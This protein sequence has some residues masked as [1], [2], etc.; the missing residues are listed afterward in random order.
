MPRAAQSRPRL[1]PRAPVPH[2]NRATRRA[3][4][5]APANQDPL[6]S[7]RP[8]IQ[9]RSTDSRGQFVPRTL[10][11][12]PLRRMMLRIAAERLYRRADRE[13]HVRLVQE[14]LE[15]R[16][17]RGPRA[18]VWR[19]RDNL[20]AAYGWKAGNSRALGQLCGRARG[21]R[22]RL[23]QEGDF[24]ASRCCRKHPAGIAAVSASVSFLARLGVQPAPD[25]AKH[26]M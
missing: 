3:P 24:R 26:V 1:G 17:F 5:S 6:L 14:T 21:P 19:R 23:H 11:N 15:T 25:R 8:L 4:R 10:A 18:L 13:P 22:D 2:A 12:P 7:S 9:A 16:F 20:L